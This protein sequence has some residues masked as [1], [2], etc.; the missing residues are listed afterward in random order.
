[1]GYV[2]RIHTFH[3]KRTSTGPNGTLRTYRLKPSW[4]S[5]GVSAKDSSLILTRY[6]PRAT[7]VETSFPVYAIGRPICS[8]ISLANTS[9]LCEMSWRAFLTMV[10]LSLRDVFLYESNAL[11]DLAG[12][13]FNSASVRPLRS[14]MGLLVMGEMVVIVSAIFVIF[15]YG[16]QNG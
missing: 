10:C 8:V 13:S 9:S 11:A 14:T 3:A 4:A 7:A 12:S 16:F 6:S 1:M 5:P 15:W 2:P